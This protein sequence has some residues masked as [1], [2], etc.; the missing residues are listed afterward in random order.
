V[1][2]IAPVVVDIE[3][4]GPGAYA[5]RVIQTGD[6]VARTSIRGTT[7]R[8]SPI[9]HD[10][11]RPIQWEEPPSLDGRT[12]EYQIV[13]EDRPRRMM[14]LP[15]D[16]RLLNDAELSACEAICRRCWSPVLL[17]ATGAR[18]IGVAPRCLC[19]SLL[20]KYGHEAFGATEFVSEQVVRKMLF[21]M[22][23]DE[24]GLSLPAQRDIVRRQQAARR[25]DLAQEKR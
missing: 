8:W 23:M 5:L 14:W 24:N 17:S 7:K 3:D 9:G 18:L 4:M 15:I 12:I 2:T 19:S 25:E 1:V 6:V 11:R 21:A 22:G 20:V 13:G 16:R 10:P